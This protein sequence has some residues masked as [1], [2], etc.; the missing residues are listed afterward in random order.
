MVSRTSLKKSSLF[1]F[2]FFF[3]NTVV[4]TSI[5]AKE[6]TAA[7]KITFDSTELDIGQIVPGEK[8]VGVFIVRNDG[9]DTLIIKRVAPT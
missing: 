8:A 7:P 4:T 3:L 6:K 9:N 1:F 5:V 2:I